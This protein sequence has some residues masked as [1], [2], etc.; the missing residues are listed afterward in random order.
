MLGFTERGLELA[1]IVVICTL[2]G[3]CGASMLWSAWNDEVGRGI[4]ILAALFVILWRA[5][6]TLGRHI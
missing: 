3:V 1:V 5:T 6:S 4:L 2:V